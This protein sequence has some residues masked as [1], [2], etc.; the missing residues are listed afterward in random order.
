MFGALE[1]QIHRREALFR[2]GTANSVCSLD[3][4]LALRDQIKSSLCPI[5]GPIVHRTFSPE[6][7]EKFIIH[8]NFYC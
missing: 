3:A 1:N 7:R 5:L 6:S 2:E 4:G 8:K